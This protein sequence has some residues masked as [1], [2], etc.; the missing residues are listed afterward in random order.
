MKH[1]LYSV[2]SVLC[3]NT[4]LY[5]AS[6][7]PSFYK[8]FSPAFFP[9]GLETLRLVTALRNCYKIKTVG[10]MVEKEFPSDDGLRYECVLGGG[11]E[12][13]QVELKKAALSFVQRG[14][15]PVLIYD[16]RR[17]TL[18]GYDICPWK[19]LGVVRGELEQALREAAES[20]RK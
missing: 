14:E 11:L 12:E 6:G 2:V 9:G 4:S 18:F 7:Q 17:A 10:G 8:N 1:L 15:R 19:E 3:V 16:K 20:L 5:A 13:A